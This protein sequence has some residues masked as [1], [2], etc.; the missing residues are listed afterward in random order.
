MWFLPAYMWFL[1]AYMWI[2]PAFMWFRIL[3]FSGVSMGLAKKLSDSSFG[4]EINCAPSGLNGLHLT[5]AQ[6]FTLC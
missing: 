3:W 4:V 2:L 6:G 1:P 5:N